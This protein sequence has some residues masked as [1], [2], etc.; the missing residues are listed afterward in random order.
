MGKVVKVVAG[1]ALFAGAALLTGGLSAV[2]SMGVALSAAAVAVQAAAAIAMGIG[3]S[4]VAKN[5]A[6]SPRVSLPDMERL[7]LT[8][9]AAAPRKI[10]FG[11][12]AMA[13]DL[14]YVEPSGTDQEYVDAIVHVA[15]HKVAGID[16][17]RIDDKVAWTL[18]GG[19][20]GDFAGYLWI[21]PILEGGA[22]AYHTVNTGSVWGATRRLTGLASFKLRVK[23]TGNSKK[24]QSP[25][26]AGVPTRM[27]VQGR[28]IPV[29]DPRRDSTRGGSGSHRADNQA[30]WQFV[31]GGSDLGNNHALQALAWLIGWRIGGKVS[32]GVGLPLARIDFAAFAAAANICDEAVALAGGGTQRRYEGAGLFNDSDDPGDVMAAFAAAVNGWWDDS[33]GKLGLFCAVNDLAGALFTLTDD[34]VLGPIQWSPFPDIAEQYNVV[35]G[36]NPDPALPANYQ[37]TDYPEARLASVD[38]IDRTMAL[39]FAMVQDKRR[40]QRLAKQVLQRQQYRGLCNLT[41]GLRGWQLLRGQP[42]KFTSYAMGWSEKLFRVESWALQPA[43]DVALT[44]REEDTSIYAWAA[45]ESPAVV[46]ATPITYNPMNNPF[47]LIED[48][49]PGPAGPPGADGTNGTNGTNG[50]DGADGADG[51]PGLSI[52]ASP[53][54]MNVGLFADGSPKPGELPQTTQLTLYDGSTNVTALASYALVGLPTNCTAAHVSGGQFNL[55]AVTALPASFTVQASY[56]GRTINQKISI[57]A[58]KDGPAASRNS[59][60]LGAPNSSGSLVSIGSADLVVAAGATIN[61]GGS[62]TY[63]CSTSGGGTRTVQLAAAVSLENLTDSGAPSV[64]SEVGGS[65]AVYITGDGDSEIGQVACAASY[66]NGTGVPKTFRAKFYTRKIAGNGTARTAGGDYDGTITISAA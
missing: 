49:A 27:V 52:A 28:G 32:V 7:N 1:A 31:D 58:P 62:L 15:S 34:D 10:V 6:R 43:G 35:R 42:I 60:V 20:Q 16:E 33:N 65:T 13:T 8:S 66:T 50:A 44:L 4:T 57:A 2:A 39:N 61:V 41:V 36:L 14:R 46:P 11:T 38:G 25:F 21:T 51:A 22:G 29:Y 3:L 63:R 59:G 17:I 47:L 18:A 26:A 12:T 24:G 23:R 9:V 64:S 37:P 53:S 55:S 45:S 30:T 40:A 5:L 56:G 19:A 54:V 48:G